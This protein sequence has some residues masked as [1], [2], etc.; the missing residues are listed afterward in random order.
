[1]SVAGRFILTP[2]GGGDTCKGFY[3]EGGY[4]SFDGRTPADGG[5][6]W[7]VTNQEVHR[8]RLSDGS[9]TLLGKSYEDS[10]TAGFASGFYSGGSSQNC[11]NGR[12]RATKV[13]CSGSCEKSSA[14]EVE[15][16]RYELLV[17]KRTSLQE[18]RVCDYGAGHAPVLFEAFMSG[19]FRRWTVTDQQVETET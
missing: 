8:L 5:Y 15:P 16:C 4:A 11:P 13:L 18:A 12:A 10:V 2:V 19:K 1:M 14:V 6:R 3:R 9:R 7:V 17:C